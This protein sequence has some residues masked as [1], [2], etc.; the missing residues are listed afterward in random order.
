MWAILAMRPWVRIAATTY[1][2]AIDNLT[3]ATGLVA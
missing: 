1:Q 3:C 2:R